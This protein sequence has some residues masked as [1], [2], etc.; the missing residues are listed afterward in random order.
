[1][2]TTAAKCPRLAPGRAFTVGCPRVAVAMLKGFKRIE[3]KPETS[4]CM[5][6]GWYYLHVGK[7]PLQPAMADK[8]TIA[9]EATWP[10]APEAD[11]L[12]RSSVYGAVLVGKVV[13]ASA[14]ET[15]WAF[16]EWPK[17]HVILESHELQSPIQGV[18]GQQS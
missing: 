12:P 6:V 5:P 10:G 16:A 7:R 4:N 9:M 3:S 14:L 2:E 18:K 11:A 17:A 13:D 1:M 8:C 15:P